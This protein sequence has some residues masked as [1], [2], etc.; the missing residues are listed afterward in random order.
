MS[1]LH[2]SELVE[3]LRVGYIKVAGFWT[4]VNDYRAGGRK[5]AVFTV[6]MALSCI[7]YG[8]LAVFSTIGMFHVEANIQGISL[9]ILHPMSLVQAFV[10]IAV[11]WLGL[12]T[13]ARLFD[14]LKSDFLENVPENERKTTGEIL[15]KHASKTT[16]IVKLVISVN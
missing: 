11:F 15:R 6:Y 16:R 3:G 1:P 5:N 7:L 12:D 4:I 2:D 8:P 14:V 9:C 13:Q 10:K